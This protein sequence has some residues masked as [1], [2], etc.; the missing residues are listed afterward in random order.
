M[1]AAQP[2]GF[3]APHERIVEFDKR[4]ILCII[5]LA[6]REFRFYRKGVTMKLTGRQ[7]QFLN[8]FLDLYRETRQPLHYSAVAERLGV[9]A[10]T[11]YDMLRLLE[12]RGLLASEYVLPE[13]GPGR[14]I[15]V[16]RPTGKATALMAQLAGEGWDG[17]EW[18][19]VKERILQALR[20]G[21]GTDYQGLQEEILLRIPER[22]S[23]MLYGAEMIT[24]VILSLHQLREDASAAGLFDRLRALGLPGEAGL[25]ALAGLALGLSFAERINR[26]LISL[27][28]S[29]TGRY[30]EIL[31]RLS[32]ENL[33]RLS[34]FVGEVMKIVET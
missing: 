27:L 17:E 22:K 28:L 3:A 25:R 19:G 20:E 6:F 18:E 33:Q 11:A 24:A 30:Q 29:Y 23:P 10:M 12:E 8:S 1:P 31:S 2:A 5:F 32:T 7:R 21:R 16:F 13:Q 15:I 34:N 14:S 4:K 9:S 26:R